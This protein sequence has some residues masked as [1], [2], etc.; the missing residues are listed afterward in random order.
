[1]TDILSHFKGVKSTGPNSWK[2]LC[3]AHNDR[4]PSLS[5]KH[6]DGKWLIHCHTKGCSPQEI[7]KAAGL[8]MS[9]LFDSPGQSSSLQQPTK[10]KKDEEEEPEGEAADI[11]E[12]QVGVT[13]R[14]YAAAKRLDVK[15][16]KQ[17]GLSDIY[18]FGK[19]A[20]SIAY[21]DRAGNVQAIR[22]RLSLKG[23]PRFKWKSGAKTCLYGLNR[24]P[25]LKPP[26]A[27][28]LRKVAALAEAGATRGEQAAAVH[29]FRE[30]EAKWE[31]SEILLVEGESDCHT[32]WH[33]KFTALG[34]PGVAMWNEARDAELLNGFGTI[35][36]VVEPGALDAIVR[37]LEHSAIR[38]RV[39]LIIDKDW[40]DGL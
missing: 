24:L 1:M 31:A 12:E 15:F 23:E 40:K 11:D 10:R 29:K 17:V 14:E 13:L 20:I 33:H 27:D 3:P 35:Y 26:D 32:L 18:Y 6:E 5:I 39:K 21:H 16:L 4:K 38:S 28:R 25:D 30:M 37:W 34:L 19:Q 7:V 9:D 8:R 36:I 22:F 2:A